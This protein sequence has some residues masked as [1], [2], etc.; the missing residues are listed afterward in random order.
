MDQGGGGELAR[1]GLRPRVL[2]LHGPTS[3]RAP[4]FV[5]AAERLGLEV[6]RGLDLPNALAE[7]WGV[8]AALDF[9][10]PEATVE[11]IA[12]LHAA[13]PFA[14]VLAVD[15]A[16][17]LL[18]ARAANRLG[19]PA[20]D[21][22]AALAARDKWVMRER[23]TA[24]GVPVPAYRRF[25][26]EAAPEEVAREVAAS[27]GFP[28]V[29]KPL[30]LSGSRGVIRADDAATFAA[31]WSRSRRIVEAEAPPPEAAYLL[32]EEYL[33]GV[34][35]AVEGLLTGGD[36]RTLAIFDKPDPLDGPFFEETIYV[37]PS[38][39][40]TET[41][42]AISARTAE[43]AAAVGLR[44][45]PVHAE[46]RINDEGIWPIELAGR[47]I[48]GLCS[49]VLEF[50]LGTT[51]EALILRHAVGWDLPPPSEQA[52]EAAGVMMIPIPRAGLL[53][54]WSGEDAARAVPGV[55][56]LEITAKPNQPLAALPEASS[57][58]G[59]LFARGA[60]PAA[61][62]ASLRQAHAALSFRIERTIELV[63]VAG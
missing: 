52:G 2:L 43:A 58:L 28:C 54:G 31:A 62:E 39:L 27:P 5:A 38:R 47:S 48:G 45:G 53:R 10:N 7:E 60:T 13:D 42:V 46:L 11:T 9:A 59:F 14:A 25:P 41:Q 55:T 50:G 12:A 8:E 36:L 22:G 51:L 40:P 15:D 33:P 21:S 37:T 20:N 34:E 4:A 57:Y 35:V 18:A 1:L 32:V 56:G 19:F 29:V 6:V 44:E 17:T 63:P 49:S 30:R 3:Y 23:F 24:A 61:A 26:L 16:A